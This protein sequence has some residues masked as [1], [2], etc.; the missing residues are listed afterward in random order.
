MKVKLR[1]I[2]NPRQKGRTRPRYDTT[3]LKDEKL[4]KAFTIALKNRYELP[5]EE[6][7]EQVHE[8]N[9]EREFN[10]MM[11]AH[12]EA[13]K[14][15]LGKPRRKKKPWISD[16]SSNLIEEREE[17][18][19][20]TLGTRPERVKSQLRKKY[21]EKKSGVKKSIGTDKRIWMNGIANKPEDA[22]R[23]QHMR[24]L[25]GVTKTLCNERSRRSAVLD[26]EGNLLGSKDDTQARWREHFKE[27]LNREAQIQIR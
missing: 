2:T 22:A 24:T 13:A 16:R 27:I 9:I 26:K 3:K 1:L 6:E 17:I 8:E 18:D 19:R 23:N 5:K 4:R 15:V 20:K 21:G 7:R 11:K 12:T 25:Y 10:V 14:T